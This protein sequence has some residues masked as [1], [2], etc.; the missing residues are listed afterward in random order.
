MR[1][2]DPIREVMKQMIEVSQAELDV[3][4]KDCFTRT[5]KRKD[6]LNEPYKRADHVYFINKGIIRV[7]IVDRQGTDNTIH[8]ALENR[9]IADYASFL[10]GTKSIQLLEALEPTEVVVIPRKVVEW[11]YE[12]MTEGEKLG[13]LIAEYYF[14]YLDNRI[15]NIY[16]KTPKERYDEITEIFPNIHNRAPQHMIASYLGITSVHLSRLKKESKVKT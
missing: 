8:F 14:V 5:Y 10:Q 15:K 3:F 6:L 2:F 11:G 4:L 1:E 16:T 13:R 9:F 12:N 7:V